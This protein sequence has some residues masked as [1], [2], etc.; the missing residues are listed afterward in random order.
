[1]PVTVTLGM[2][3]AV[4]PLIVLVVPENVCEPVLV[5]YVPL[6]VR[7]PAILKVAATYSVSVPLIVT[8]DPNVRFPAT[9]SDRIPPLLIVT[10]PVKVLFAAEVVTASVPEVPPPMCLYSLMLFHHRC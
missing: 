1:V 8:S 3:V 10:D 7:F 5:L 9:F 2:E 6:L 4:V